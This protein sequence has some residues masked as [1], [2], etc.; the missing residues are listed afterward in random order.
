MLG[1]DTIL[2]LLWFFMSSQGSE[3]EKVMWYNRPD[4]TTN[5]FQD[6]Y[7][8][9][10]QVEQVEQYTMSPEE[11]RF[12]INMGIIIFIAGVMIVY[13]IINYGVPSWMRF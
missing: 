2:S 6:R 1:I 4:F 11:E 3:P 8:E 10:P 12:R 13:Y 9:I 5:V 7:A